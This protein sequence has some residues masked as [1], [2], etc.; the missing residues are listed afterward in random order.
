MITFKKCEENDLDLLHEIAL[1]S[2]NDTY[3]YLWKDGGTS[4]LNTF[5]K[6]DI[7]K[8]ELSAT[9]IYYFLIYEDKNAIGYFKLKESAIESYSADECMELDKLYL[10]KKYTGK[11]IG[12]TIM[13]YIL[14]FSKEKNRSILW[15][16]VMESSPA[17]FVYEKSGFVPINK[18]DLTYPEIIEEY[19]SIITMICKI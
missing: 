12:K 1:Q 3:Q 18:Y 4:Y 7:F 6:K 5:Y 15:L 10:L 8:N 11:G 19:A 16:K 9:N 2:Y 14:S 13:N 17:R